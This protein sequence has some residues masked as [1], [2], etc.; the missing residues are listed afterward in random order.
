MDLI[1]DASYDMV[2]N[3]KRKKKQIFLGEWKSWND[4]RYGKKTGNIENSDD[5]R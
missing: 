5:R 4:G 3:R 1:N 2:P